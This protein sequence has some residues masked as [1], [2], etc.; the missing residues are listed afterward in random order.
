MTTDR[1]AAAAE[2]VAAARLARTALDILP[3]AIRPGDE[4][5]AYAVQD[6]VHARLSAGG[7]GARIGYKIACTTKVMQEY[8]GIGS[9]CSAGLFAAGRH[10]SGAVVRADAYA[11]IGV[12]CEIA[13]RIGRDLTPSDAPFTAAGIAGAIAAFMPAIEIVDDRY[14]DWRKTDAPTLIADDFFS[15]GSV[16]GAPVDPAA[17]AD[18]A[19]LVGTT[20]INGIEAGRGV[21]ADV[22][23]HPL[24]ALA[25]LANHLAARGRTLARDEIVLTGSLVETKWLAAGDRVLIAITGLGP[26]ALSVV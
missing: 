8:L 20:V 6:A 26:V 2:A 4:G 5:E 16:L 1:I 10:Q 17:V 25:W 24:N 9:P 21:G 15:A 13:V 3:A 22:M 12:E 18:P 14:A 7:H 23:G 19:G 11:R